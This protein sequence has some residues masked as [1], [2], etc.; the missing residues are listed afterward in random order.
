M[1]PPVGIRER[2]FDEK[3][4]GGASAAVCFTLRSFSPERLSEV[5]AERDE[6]TEMFPYREKVQDWN[7][8]IENSEA[9][10]LIFCQTSSRPAPVLAEN[11]ITG[12]AG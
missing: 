7:S 4:S 9:D 5:R 3:Q 1:L 2:E 6:G 12:A 8:G 10:F 11:G